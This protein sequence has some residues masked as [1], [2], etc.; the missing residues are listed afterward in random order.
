MHLR[1]RDHYIIWRHMRDDEDA[2]DNSYMICSSAVQLYQWKCTCATW[3][4]QHH[5]HKERMKAT[6]FVFWSWSSRI[7]EFKRSNLNDKHTANTYRIVHVTIYEYTRICWVSTCIIRHIAGGALIK[8]Q[9]QHMY[10][11]SVTT[12]VSIFSMTEI[13]KEELNKIKC[14]VFFIQFIM[15]F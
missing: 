11:Y 10:I 15:F 12:K 8:S 7:F 2:D 5:L 4:T 1:D 13:L 9:K 6:Q 14:T 3:R